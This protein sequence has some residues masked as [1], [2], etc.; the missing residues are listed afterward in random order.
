MVTVHSSR[1]DTSLVLLPAHLLA[2]LLFDLVSRSALALV[3]SLMYMGNPG[4]KRRWGLLLAFQ[5]C[6][7]G[8][9]TEGRWKKRGTSQAK[10]LPP[11]AP[12]SAAVDTQ[13][14][15]SSPCQC[16][17]FDNKEP[18]GTCQPSGTFWVLEPSL[19]HR[20]W[21]CPKS[22]AQAANVP[23]NRTHP[24]RTAFQTQIRT[25]VPPQPP[26]LPIVLWLCCYMCAFKT[27]GS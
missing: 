23:R 4:C 24:P 7:L 21:G 26:P 6:S 13:E 22:W 19:I 11:G 1:M 15:F 2:P 20:L 27:S 12:G 25:P 14:P 9:H 8:R 16:N 18:R 5:P 3:C 10:H 17:S